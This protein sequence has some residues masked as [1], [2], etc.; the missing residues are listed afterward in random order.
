MNA[1]FAVLIDLLPMS[2]KVISRFF[3]F[4][5]LFLDRNLCACRFFMFLH[6]NLFSASGKQFTK[7]RS[8]QIDL[9]DFEYVELLPF[10]LAFV[11][12]RL[13]NEKRKKVSQ[14]NKLNSR[15]FCFIWVESG[16]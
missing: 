14:I 10:S 13:V 12:N 5:C 9:Q 3:A 4:V 2:R 7:N 6:T 11:P 8:I 1:P 15:G 16:N